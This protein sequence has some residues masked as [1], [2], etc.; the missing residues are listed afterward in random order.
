MHVFLKFIFRSTASPKVEKVIAFTGKMPYKVCRRR[1]YMRLL[2]NNVTLF[3]RLK[4]H[5]DC[6]GCKC[7]M[8]SS[9]ISSINDF[10]FN[11]LDGIYEYNSNNHYSKETEDAINTAK[12][13]LPQYRLFIDDEFCYK[14]YTDKSYYIH[15]EV[16]DLTILKDG[17]EGLLPGI[18]IT[19]KKK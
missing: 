15:R 8:V 13:Y 12:K 14:I 9:S 5:P 18:H 6:K 2:N 10:L 16:D 17:I 19:I 4:D 3:Y 1:L 11:V 7:L